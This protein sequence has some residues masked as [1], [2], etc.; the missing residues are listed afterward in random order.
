V[1]RGLTQCPLILTFSRKGEK[2]QEG[3]GEDRR[4]VRAYAFEKVTLG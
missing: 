1:I 2:A 3:T 4:E